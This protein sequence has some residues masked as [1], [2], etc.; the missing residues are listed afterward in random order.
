MI[1]TGTTIITFLMVFL[2]QSTQN[3]DEA[4]HLKLNELIHAGKNAQNE[5]IEVEK[6]SD[7][8]LKFLE[9]YYADLAKSASAGARAAEKSRPPGW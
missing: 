5:L 6:L 1:N 2:I 8:Q 9:E 4:I 3:R 7:E